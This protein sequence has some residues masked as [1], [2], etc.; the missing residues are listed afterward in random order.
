MDLPRVQAFEFNDSARTP[1]F[2]R[3]LV[4]ESL[5]RTLQ[6]GHVLRGL[7][8]PF[9]RFLA[10]SGATEVLDLCA[11]A[12]GPATILAS[13]MRAGG[14]PPP[15][16]L[17][18]DLY[19]QMDAWEAARAEHPGDIDFVQEPVDATRIPE[20]LAKGRARAIIN[21]FHHFP[22]DIARELLADAVRGSAGI[23]V[24]EAFERN[25][26]GFLPMTAAGLP[27]LLANPILSKRDRLAKAAVT[28][29]S[30][31]AAGISLWDG[32]VSTLRIYSERDLREMVAPLGD[33]FTWEYG[34]YAF[35][36]LGKGAYFFGVPRR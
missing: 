16:F 32:I 21:A 4:V 14:Q 15:R 36:P 23:F 30:P 29:L 3:D 8:P 9:Q 34:N 19:P 13:E 24:S 22:P 7:V 2:L 26:L 28:W 6:W 11:G 1:K 12:A 10:A 5:S 27:A 20:H 18:T 17:L 33:S 25:P 35:A 31:I